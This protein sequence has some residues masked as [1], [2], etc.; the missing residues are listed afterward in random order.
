MKWSS[1]RSRFISGVESTSA[2]CS[3]SSPDRS[4]A[5][6]LWSICRYISKPTAAMAPCC[7]TPS[8]LR[9]PR[10]VE[11]VGVGALAGAADASPQLIQLG[12]SEAV[13]V[14]DDQR[15]DVGYVEPR[16]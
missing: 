3:S 12:K 4:L 1:G 16:L 9:A 8:R 2:I 11:E 15:V 10:V 5:T 14:L 6:A 13:G 7:S